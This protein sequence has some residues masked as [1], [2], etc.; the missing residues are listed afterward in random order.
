M[1]NAQMPSDPR[2]SPSLRD[3]VG[4]IHAAIVTES[5]TSFSAICND[6]YMLQS[7]QIGQRL[8]KARKKLGLPQVDLAVAVGC[9]RSYISKLESGEKLASYELYA[10]MAKELKISFSDLMGLSETSLPNNFQEILNQP[11]ALQLLEIFGVLSE[12]EQIILLRIA[13]GLMGPGQP[14]AP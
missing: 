10:K 7:T 9:N 11:R 12:D 6:S 1:V 4:D 14:D 3:D 2:R 13:A 5:H 8:L